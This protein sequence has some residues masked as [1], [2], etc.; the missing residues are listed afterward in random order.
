MGRISSD[1]PERLRRG[2]YAAT[3]YVRVSK[4][5]VPDLVYRDSA[6]TELLNDPYVDALVRGLRFE[7]ALDKGTP[8]D[9]VAAFRLSQLLSF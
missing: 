9:G 7:P 5:G 1:L 8:V 3:L 4:Q 6:C 2:Q